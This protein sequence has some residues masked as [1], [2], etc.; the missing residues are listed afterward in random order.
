MLVMISQRMINGSLSY[1][2]YVYTNLGEVLGA[3]IVIV[4][5][6]FIPIYAIYRV[7]VTEGTLYEVSIGFQPEIMKK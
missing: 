7:Y 1:G 5:I 2:K 4:P 6:L 3:L